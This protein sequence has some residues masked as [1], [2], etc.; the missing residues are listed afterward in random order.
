LTPQPQLPPQVMLPQ[1]PPLPPVHAAML[2]PGAVP[3]APMMMAQPQPHVMPQ[4]MPIPLMP[5][6]PPPAPVMLMQPQQQ[7]PAM[8]GVPMTPGIMAPTMVPQFTQPPTP[9]LL[10]GQP[11]RYQ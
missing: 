1:A 7:Q 9:Q 4:P 5:M 11:L 2:P 3:G 8:P 6:M 10:A